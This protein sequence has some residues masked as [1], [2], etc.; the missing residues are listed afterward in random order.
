MRRCGRRILV[1]SWWDVALS[2]AVILGGGLFF[3]LFAVIRRLHFFLWLLALTCEVT[4]LVSRSLDTLLL[5]V[6]EHN[7][8]LL[9]LLQAGIERH[10]HARNDKTR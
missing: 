8:L 6:S 2:N 1:G 9:F 5:A 10:L 3:S 7:L 4:H